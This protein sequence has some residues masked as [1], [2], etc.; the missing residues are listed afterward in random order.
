M[1]CDYDGDWQMAHCQFRYVWDLVTLHS[2]ADVNRS[3]FIR[4]N[5][6]FANSVRGK[7]TITVESLQALDRENA[8]DIF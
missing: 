3:C 7:V 1:P 6:L 8:G 4:H 2:Y 5:L